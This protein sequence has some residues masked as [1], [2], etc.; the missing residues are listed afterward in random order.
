ML[1]GPLQKKKKQEGHKHRSRYAFF[2]FNR[3]LFPFT[4][5]AKSWLEMWKKEKRVDNEWQKDLFQSLSPL[6]VSS[7]RTAFS[8][9]TNAVSSS[10][11]VCV[12]VCVTW[13]YTLFLR[14]LIA[15]VLFFWPCNTKRKTHFIAVTKT[16]ADERDRSTLLRREKQ[17]Q[18]AHNSLGEKKKRAP[19]AANMTSLA[20]NFS[21]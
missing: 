21:T 13:S 3:A 16:A 1:T 2:F 9:E 7:L 14:F 4:T 10:L 18:S 17:L 12:C 8:L 20:Q 11:L 15:I 19:K 5:V 6:T